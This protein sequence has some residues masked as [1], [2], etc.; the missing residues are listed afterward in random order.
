MIRQCQAL[1]K[2]FKKLNEDQRGKAFIQSA[3]PFFKA[4]GVPSL[5]LS[6]RKPTHTI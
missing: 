2:D 6:S 4:Y 3:N 5:A 1:P